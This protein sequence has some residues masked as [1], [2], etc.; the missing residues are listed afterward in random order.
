[1]A[2]PLAGDSAANVLG[3]T[4]LFVALGATDEELAR[5]LPLLNEV[6]VPASPLSVLRIAREML[7]KVRNG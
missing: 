3:T 2:E 1:M 4:A 7:E 5:I 6:Q